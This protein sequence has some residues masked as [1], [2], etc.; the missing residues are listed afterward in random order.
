MAKILKN[1]SKRNHRRTALIKDTAEIVGVSPSMVRKVLNTDRNNDEVIAVHMELQ[2][3]YSRLIDEVKK[4][5]PFN[6]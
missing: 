6:K 4:L 5:V 2:E 1:N 3:G